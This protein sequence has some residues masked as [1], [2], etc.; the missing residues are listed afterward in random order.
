M[1]ARSGD[2]PSGKFAP[3]GKSDSA[4][5]EKANKRAV[6]PDVDNF[7][8]FFEEAVSLQTNILSLFPMTELQ[9]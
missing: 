3:K 7:S 2:Y 6:Q 1:F 4:D 5:A 9:L 8:S